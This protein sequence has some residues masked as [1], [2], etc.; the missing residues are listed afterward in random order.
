M[1]YRKMFEKTDKVFELFEYVSIYMEMGEL[2]ETKSR[3]S[4][5]SA[6]QF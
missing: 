4:G 5:Q 2:P 1:K 6:L 3:S